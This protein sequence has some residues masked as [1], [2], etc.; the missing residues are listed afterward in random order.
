M[1]IDG[2][3][4]VELQAGL[5]G[6]LEVQG[7]RQIIGVFPVSE[8]RDLATLLPVA[9]LLLYIYMYVSTVSTYICIYKSKKK[10]KKR[11]KN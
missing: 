4:G 6:V 9:V 11:Q 1:E 5:P 10:K 7:D 8:R 2:R 3:G